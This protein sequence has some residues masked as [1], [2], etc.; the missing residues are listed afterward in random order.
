MM[1]LTSIVQDVGIVLWLATKTFNQW[2]AC[3]ASV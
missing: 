2:I 3:Q 1:C